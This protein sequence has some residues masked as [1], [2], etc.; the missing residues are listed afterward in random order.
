[1]TFPGKLGKMATVAKGRKN[2]FF[3]DFIIDKEKE[4]G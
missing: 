4:S 1:L 3:I 2:K